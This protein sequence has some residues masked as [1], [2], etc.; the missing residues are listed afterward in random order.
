[1]FVIWW[2]NNLKQI[3]LTLILDEEAN[4]MFEPGHMEKNPGPSALCGYSSSQGSAVV[5]EWELTYDFE[6]LECCLCN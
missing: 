4:R 5:K 6:V 3:L 2:H 1:M